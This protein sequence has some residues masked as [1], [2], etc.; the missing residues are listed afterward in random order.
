MFNQKKLFGI[1]KKL[2]FPPCLSRIALT[3][4]IH[5]GHDKPPRVDHQLII[6]NA[7]KLFMVHSKDALMSKFYL[8]DTS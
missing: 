3:D 6:P 1:C 2:T 5:I 4:P 7:E 8:R